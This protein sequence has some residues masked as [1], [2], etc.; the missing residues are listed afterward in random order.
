MQTSK[1][2]ALWGIAAI[3]L[4]AIAASGKAWAAQSS[5]DASRPA[6]QGSNSSR[7]E[8]NLEIEIPNVEDDALHAKVPGANDPWPEVNLNVVVLSKQGAPQTVDV[9]GFQLFEDKA[10]RPL[11]FRGSADSPVSLGLLIDSSHSMEKRGPAISA[12]VTTI[13]KALPAGSEAMAVLFDEEAYLDLPFTPASEIDYAFLDRVNAHG[14]TALND[15]VVVAEKYFATHAR[16]ARRAMILLSDGGDNAS[17]SDL[18]D[19]LPSLQWPGAPTFYSFHIPDSQASG[20]DARFGRIA[21]EILAKEGGGVAFTPKEKDFASAA[22][23]L[24][25]MIRSQYVLHFTAADPARDGK[26]HKLEVRLPIKDVQIHALPVYYA[27]AN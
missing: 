15:A 6:T 22:A 2:C 10:E 23:R 8:L 12:L 13:V 11:H 7:P 19:I 27:P 18:G 21:M 1:K 24:A 5:G 26:A 9:S 25:D 3:A 4:L 16:Y 17:K 14:G 20:A